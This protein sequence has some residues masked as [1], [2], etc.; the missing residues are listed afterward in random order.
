MTLSRWPRRRSRTWPVAVLL[1]IL[2]APGP[3]DPWTAAAETR[4]VLRSSDAGI[5]RVMFEGDSITQ[6][7]NGEAS[8][9]YYLW[10]E[11]QRQGVAA[12]FVGPYSAPQKR[13]EAPASYWFDD[14]DK[15][16][17]AKAGSTFKYH[18]AY[19]ISWLTTYHPD[20]LVLMLGINDAITRSG[21]Q[22]AG[23]TLEFLT[24]AWGVDP[25]LRVVLAQIT[26]T[27]RGSYVDRNAASNLAN[28]LV[29][30]KLADDPRV[31]FAHTRQGGADPAL[32]WDPSILT[33]DG[34]H[35]NATG[36][37]WLAQRL[38]QAL[39]QAGYLPRGDIDIYR[40]VQ[41]DPRPRN[42]VHV[43]GRQV[44]VSWHS[45]QLR[46]FGSLERVKITTAR[47][48]RVAR[49][50]WQTGDEWS[51]RLPA[52][53]YRAVVAPR[54]GTMYGRYGVVTWFRIG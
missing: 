36:D 54:K 2:A 40:T 16:H 48:R 39:H 7:R 14:F 34:T 37:T 35:P 9:R 24:R 31:V 12:D 49:S 22:I 50:T 11:F 51:T 1:I 46:L 47:G 52:G 27:K 43:S 18:S 20:V 19:E 29:A 15:D 28:T 17:A 10:R 21:D 38:A 4:V 6:S 26:S 25:G 5:V 45:A 30:S 3:R 13:A 42:V 41:W 53:R 23:D 8:Y 32:D 44:A 33:F